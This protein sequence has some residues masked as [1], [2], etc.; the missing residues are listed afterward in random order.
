MV[1]TAVPQYP[2]AGFPGLPIGLNDGRHV[3]S[4]LNDSP[5]TQGEYDLTITVANTHDYLL[6]LNSIALTYTSD[7][8]ATEAEIAAGIKAAIFANA[9]AAGLVESA[10]LVGHAV[11]V[12]EKAGLI[13]AL[14]ITGLIA[15]LT[16]V[17]FWL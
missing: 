8:S 14:A 13:G 4:M 11:R 10:E 2:D 16:A 3:R 9:Y 17:E 12:V 1:L 6:S 15:T 7:G 5:A